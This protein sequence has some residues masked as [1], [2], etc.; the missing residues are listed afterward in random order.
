MRFLVTG[1]TGSFG[2][3]VI[4]KLLAQTDAEIICLSRDE[5]KQYDLKNEFNSDRVKY[6]IGNIRNRH[7]IEPCFNGVDYVFHA[8]ALK[9]IPACQENPLQATL[10]NVIGSQNVFES[11]I[12]NGV[13]K[14]VYLSTDKVVNPVSVMGMTKSIAEQIAINNQS[15]TEIIITR[16]CNIA[17][18]QGSVIPLWINQIKQ[19]KDLTLTCENMTRYF[20]DVND[21]V[22]LVLTA[23]NQGKQGEIFIKKAKQYN[24]KLIAES[25]IKIFNSSSKVKLIGIR[26]GE[27]MSEQL[28]GDNE[29]AI[30]KD[31]Y[32]ILSKNGKLLQLPNVVESEEETFKAVQKWIENYK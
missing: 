11:A 3:A 24:L 23:F 20:M 9:Q 8:A 12:K 2:K 31:G 1:G 13:K 17:I 32:Y 15:K 22:D 26:D 30:E 27:K 5:K 21:A 28:F 25:L 10:T 29:L 7:D 6:I 19:E 16:F 14:V 4:K 18:S